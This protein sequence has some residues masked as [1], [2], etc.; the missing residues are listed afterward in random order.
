MSIFNKIYIFRINSRPIL[1]RI[2]IPLAMW[3]MR[4]VN[5][6]SQFY[7]NCSILIEN[8]LCDPYYFGHKYPWLCRL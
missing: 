3:A 2:K 7:K 1:F 6:H 8:W 4:T 5:S